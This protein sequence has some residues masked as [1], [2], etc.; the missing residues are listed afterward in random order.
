MRG[1]V[2]SEPPLGS[3]LRFIILSGVVRIHFIAKFIRF[4][5][6]ISARLL[7]C[8]L[9]AGIV[10]RSGQRRSGFSPVVS[11]LAAVWHA[12][13]RLLA[14]PIIYRRVLV[15]SCRILLLI[16]SPCGFW[17]WGSL[18]GESKTG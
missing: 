16:G 9:T 15:A 2:W 13:P 4:R 11:S 18:S 8:A 14:R 3:A 6:S 10:G 12:G 17:H 1:S 7:L 5:V